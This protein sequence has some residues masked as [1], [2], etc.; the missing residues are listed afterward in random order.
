MPESRPD[1]QTLRGI[2]VL[3]T[4]PAHQAINLARLIEQAGGS[5]I[6]FPTIDIV[7]PADPARLLALLERLA[8]FDLAIF[9]SPNAVE[10]TFGWLRSQRR[11]WPAELRVACV[12]PGSARALAQAGIR[13][14]LVPAVGA[15]SEALLTLPALQAVA[16]KRVVIFRGGGGRELLADTLK[17][18]GA[19]V[20][21]AE[22][23]RRARPTADT[24]KLVD[25][26]RNDR[27][28]VVSITSTDGLR[29]LYGMLGDTDRG[30][31]LHTPVVV[32]SK[33]Q[34]AE[35]RRLGFAN[36]ALIATAGSDE[37]ILETIKAWRLGRF[38]L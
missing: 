35:C 34:A 25:T 17:Q 5:A 19:T 11:S 29:N 28:H 20:T 26:W 24:A 18:R 10:Q 13:D 6:L 21:Y 1:K 30:W 4:R 38:S 16:G 27:I 22:C 14:V 32:V 36:E 8:E 33:A 31:L 9:V 37:A 12:G 7:P 15:D 2:G 3:V 23:Y